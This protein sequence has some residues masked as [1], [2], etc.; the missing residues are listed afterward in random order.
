MSLIDIFS[1]LQENKHLLKHELLVQGVIE[2]IDHGVLKQGDQLPSI[3][4]M[5][6]DLGYARKTIVK[7]YESLKDRGLVESKKLKGY[8]IVS[9]ETHVT[10]RIALLL[11][12]FQRYQEEFYNSFRSELGKRFRIDV[13]F[14][15]NNITVFETIFRNIQG[16]YGKYVIAPIQDPRV[17]GLLEGIPSEKLLVVDRYVPMPGAYSFITQ[18]FHENTYKSLL[19]LV[20]EIQRFEDY[21]LFFNGS[22]EIPPDLINAFTRF[23]SDYGLKGA[24]REKYDPGTLQQNTLYICITDSDLWE[25]IK[26]CRHHNYTPGK[27]LGIL[28]F[29]DHVVKEIVLGGITTISTDFKQMG[30]MAAEQIK[31]GEKKQVILPV[32]LYKRESL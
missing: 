11:F 10:L 16:K 3:N 19:C 18:E 26:E 30:R 24:I 20:P 1:R 4:T 29:D 25:V 6:H 5:V 2:A 22:R 28:S 12:A 23:F 21:V 9:E 27:D 17:S 14:H 13:F 8:F 32:N 31:L 15:H 7:A